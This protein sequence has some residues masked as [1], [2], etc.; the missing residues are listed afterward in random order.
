MPHDPIR[1]DRDQ[2]EPFGRDRS[3]CIDLV[4]ERQG[5]RGLVLEDEAVAERGH[6]VRAVRRDDGVGPTDHRHEVAEVRTPPHA[7]LD[8]GEHGCI[9]GVGHA[10]ACVEH[11]RTVAG[12]DE[13]RTA[14]TRHDARQP[15]GQRAGRVDRSGRAVDEQDLGVDGQTEPTAERAPHVRRD[16]RGRR[17]GRGA[18][19][20]AAFGVARVVRGESDTLRAVSIARDD[21]RHADDRHDCRRDRDQDQ[22]ALPRRAAFVL[23]R[24]RLDPAADRNGLVGDQVDDVECVVLG[25][26]AGILRHRT[27]VAPSPV[28]RTR[29]VATA[30]TAR[31][32]AAPSAPSRS[33]CGGGRCAPRAVP[34]A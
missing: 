7:G 22:P 11:H 29:G 8:S 31:R 24:L 27:I 28:R 30:A 5:I 15:V 21:D 23:V 6:R 9:I 3:R 1:M 18:G 33:R 2:E 19:A 12:H 34:A 16:V 10:S 17:P 4:P 26:A 25:F 32:A 20:G 13:Q 14:M